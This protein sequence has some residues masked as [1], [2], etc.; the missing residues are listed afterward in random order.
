V[1]ADSWSLMTNGLPPSVVARGEDGN[2]SRRTPFFFLEKLFQEVGNL[3]IHDMNQGFARTRVVANRYESKRRAFGPPEIHFCS[4][5]IVSFESK[6]PPVQIEIKTFGLEGME[7]EWS[8]SALAVGS[9]TS[10]LISHRGFR[11]SFD[12]LFEEERFKRA[13]MKFFRRSPTFKKSAE[14]VLAWGDELLAIHDEYKAYRTKL[15]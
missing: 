15:L 14:P 9:D 10:G 4:Y 6:P 7:L 3:T 12:N 8:F 5:D 1:D 2:P 13:W 11:A